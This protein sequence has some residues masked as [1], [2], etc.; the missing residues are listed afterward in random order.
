MK[1][2][3]ITGVTGQAG[4]YLSALLLGKGYRVVGTTRDI[5]TVNR[6]VDSKVELVSLD[7]TNYDRVIDL[8]DG[9]RPDEVY[10]FAAPSS[11]ARSFGD[12]V[13]TSVGIMLPTLNILE[14]MRVIGGGIRFL[15]AASIEMF[16][17]CGTAAHERTP[18]D[19][20]SPYGVA[21]TTSYLQ[22]KNFREAYD[23]HACSAIFSNFESPRR[24]VGF[25]TGKIVSSACQ[26]ARGEVAE[27]KL[28]N[29]EI[30]RDWGWA[31]EYMEA[32]WRMMQL[33]EPQDL[34][35]ATGKRRSLSDFLEIAFYAVGLK[36]EDHVSRDTHLL[37]PYDIQSSV[38]DPEKARRTIHWVAS[39]NLEELVAE[40]VEIEMKKAR[41]S[42]KSMKKLYPVPDS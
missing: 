16:G 6:P 34:V 11:V 24:P 30:Y 19:P 22:T 36:Y 29:I 12:P 7:L 35:I 8:I 15:D 41:P 4:H 32:A 17:D 40:W 28:G 31:P 38:G 26:I 42:Q 39:Y 33:D 23:L 1:T 20:H 18:L 25:V 3:L 9:L 5:A 13:R 10:H 37:R 14:S 27:L 2:A 21:K